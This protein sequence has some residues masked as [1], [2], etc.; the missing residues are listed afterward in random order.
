MKFNNTTEATV[1]V[2]HSTPC[3][4]TILV[5][6]Q[7]SIDSLIG[8]RL[9]HSGQ[10]SERSLV[11]AFGGEEHRNVY[12]V[13]RMVIAPYTRMQSLLYGAPVKAWA[14]MLSSS[15]GVPLI[16]TIQCCG[17]TFNSRARPLG[18]ASPLKTVHSQLVL[19]TLVNQAVGYLLRRPQ[20]CLEEL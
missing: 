13:M 4:G 16:G 3:T 14:Y 5:M 12:S 15:D 2:L 8:S 10:N 6:N 18:A 7:L 17:D 1:T 20:L 9:P 11:F 19:R